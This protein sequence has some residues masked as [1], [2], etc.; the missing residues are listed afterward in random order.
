MFYQDAEHHK[1]HHPQQQ[2]LPRLKTGSTQNKK[3]IA[4]STTTSLSLQL[5]K[6]YLQQLFSKG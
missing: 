4:N 5:F 2:K 6:Y 3:N 1:V